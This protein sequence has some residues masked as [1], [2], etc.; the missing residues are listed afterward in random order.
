[1]IKILFFAQVRELIETDSLSL[2]ADYATVEEVR[3]ALC[4]RGAR[5]ELALEAGKLLAAV[6]QSLVELTHP[7]QDGD[8]VAFFPPVT[9]G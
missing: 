2:P 9:G 4:Q 1:M 6:N 8:E 3:Q 5:W 7:L